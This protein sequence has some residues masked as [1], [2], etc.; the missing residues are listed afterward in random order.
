MD[1]RYLQIELIKAVGNIAKAINRIADAIE[2]RTEKEFPNPTEKM[3]NLAR[4][5]E[6]RKA[7]DLD[8]KSPKNETRDVIE[9]AMTE[10]AKK[11]IAKKD[12]RCRNCTRYKH[13]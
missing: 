9:A 2:H 6:L 11:I 4:Y 10:R 1:D 3:I 12:L 5:S 7:L 13:T 8:D